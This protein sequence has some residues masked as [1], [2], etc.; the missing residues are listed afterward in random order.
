MT[1]ILWQC[2]EGDIAVIVT[3]LRNNKIC[4]LKTTNWKDSIHPCKRR[5]N[6]KAR[7][8][9][10]EKLKDFKF[11]FWSEKYSTRWTPN[12]WNP[13]QNNQK[14]CLCIAQFWLTVSETCYFNNV[15]IVGVHR[16][17]HVHSSHVLPTLCARRYLYALEQMFMFSW[18]D[19]RRLPHRYSIACVI[20]L[21]VITYLSEWQYS[22]CDSLS[23]FCRYGSSG[24]FNSFYFETMLPMYLTLPLSCVWAAVR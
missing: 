10:R 17:F 7:F 4:I 13:I 24:F 1:T 23:I 5:T 20:L 8:R 12:Y 15:L 18:L 9:F 3:S 21:H 11:A 22:I 6:Y 14:C 19:W 16:V 2:S